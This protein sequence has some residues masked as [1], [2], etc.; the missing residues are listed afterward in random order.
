MEH[1]VCIRSYVRDVTVD[2][3]PCTYVTCTLIR[4]VSKYTICCIG[5][6]CSDEKLSKEG[7]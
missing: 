6:K 5:D 4:E 2:R 7:T 3:Q 1:I